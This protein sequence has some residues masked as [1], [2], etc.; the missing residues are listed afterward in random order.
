MMR[1]RIAPASSNAN[2][3][4]ERVESDLVEALTERFTP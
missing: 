4:R 3:L 1:L 2:G